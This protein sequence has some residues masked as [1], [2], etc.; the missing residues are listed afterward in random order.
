MARFVITLTDKN[1]GVMLDAKCYG[2][3]RKDNT[4]LA[5]DTGATLVAYYHNMFAR[6]KPWWKRLLGRK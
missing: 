3:I 2:K 1:N 5:Q 4:T 6:R